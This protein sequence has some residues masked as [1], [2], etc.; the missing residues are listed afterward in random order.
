MYIA[1]KNGEFIVN[2]RNEE[3]AS[4][5]IKHFERE[6]KRVRNYTPSYY[7]IIDEDHEH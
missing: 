1:D 3:E 2:A 7:Q 5:I 6:D 4:K